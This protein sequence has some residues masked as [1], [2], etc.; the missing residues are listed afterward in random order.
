MSTALQQR[1]GELVL[2][3][4]RL[5]GR[6]AATAAIAIG[7]ASAH[8]QHVHRRLDHVPVLGTKR[9]CD[10]ALHRIRGV[11]VERLKSP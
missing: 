8:V 11:P 4:G 6:R 9:C 7:T 3:G 10:L 5:S 2:V 1:L